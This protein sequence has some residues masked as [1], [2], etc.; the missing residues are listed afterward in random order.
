VRRRLLLSGLPIRFKRTVVF[1]A[2]SR[3]SCWSEVSAATLDATY[4]FHDV[5]GNERCAQW[6]HDGEWRE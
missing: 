5:N 6:N 3:F 4:D 2:L 1:A